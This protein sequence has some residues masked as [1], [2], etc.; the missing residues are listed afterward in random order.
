MNGSRQD[1]D[2]TRPCDVSI[3]PCDSY[4]PEAV[5]AALDACLKP[6]GGLDWVKPGMRIALKANLV[7][8]L[9]PEAA[10]TTHPEVL[11]ALT[12]LLIARGA[13]V[14]VGD[15][16]GGLFNAAFL[17]AIYDGTGMRRVEKSGAELNH[18]FEQRTARFPEAVVAKE[19]QYTAWLGKAD[20][21]IDVCKLKTHGMMGMSAAAKN[22]FGAVSGTIKPEYH[23]KY[24]NEDDFARMLLD[25]DAY[26][27]IRLCLVD[28]VVGM[29]GNGPSMGKPRKIGALLAGVSPHAV[30]LACA[31]LIGIEPRDVPTLRAAREQGLIPETL[32]ELNISGPLDALCVPDFDLIQARKSTLFDDSFGGPF[33]KLIGSFIR[34]AMGGVPAVARA[35]CVHCA[36]CANVC[37]A[38]AIAMKKGLPVIDRKKCIRCFCCQEFCP[39]GA[40]KVRRAFI[41]RALN[42]AAK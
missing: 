15:S 1:F 21:I 17:N 39:R 26:F 13:S 19:F 12:E 37:P 6:L 25:I 35:E 3:V 23:F 41:A 36:H 5:R 2:T 14:V 34:T 38:D 18:D 20:A 4:A 22:M 40:M 16:P 7:T 9:K 29:E 30:D 10:A 28:A 31:R 24:P 11:A 32:A 27:P 8:R 42:R 33:G